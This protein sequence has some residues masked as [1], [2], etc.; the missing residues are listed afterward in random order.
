[1]KLAWYILLVT[2][3]LAQ[4]SEFATGQSNYRAG[5]FKVAISH[6]Q[7]ALVANPKDAASN[8]WMG[9]SYETL[10]DIATPFGRKYRSLARTYLTAAA[11]LAPDRP[12][13]RRELFDFLLDANQQRLALGVLKASAETD[14]E[15]DYMLSRFEQTRKVNSSFNGRVCAGFRVLTFVP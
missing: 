13:Y 8:Y 2:P 5:E 3:A 15:Y 1:M 4:Q 9:R 6:F 10:A 7:R 12:E 14:P 11:E